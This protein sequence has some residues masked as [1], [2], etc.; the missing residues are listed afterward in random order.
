MN[1]NLCCANDNGSLLSSPSARA[2]LTSSGAATPASSTPLLASSILP[3]SPSTVPSS[4]ILLTPI[5]TPNT[6]RIR[7]ITCVANNEWPPSSKK[8]SPLP[9]SSFLSTSLQ[10]PPTISSYAVLSLLSS[11]F[12]S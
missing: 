4:K 3:A 2:S 12:L 11:S 1:H 8:F 9:T 10:I 5:S 6:P 7:E